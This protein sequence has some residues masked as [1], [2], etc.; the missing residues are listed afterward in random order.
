ME[1]LFFKKMFVFVLSLPNSVFQ[2]LVLHV[3][4]GGGALKAQQKCIYS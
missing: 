4:L 3:L 1:K 2:G